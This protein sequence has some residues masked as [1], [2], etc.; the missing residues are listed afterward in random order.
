MIGK[1]YIRLDSS[2]K[3]VQAKHLRQIS[4]SSSLSSSQSSSTGA[5]M[6]PQEA[7]R[8]AATGRRRILTAVIVLAA[9]LIL[10]SLASRQDVPEE[11]IPEALKL[12]LHVSQHSASAS[13]SAQ[14]EHPD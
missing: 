14:M 12:A 2:E 3:M 8:V 9:I 6:H 11:Y 1:S 4:L 5:P 10:L 13:A 7:A